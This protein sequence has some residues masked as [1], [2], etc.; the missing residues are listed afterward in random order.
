M[1]PIKHGMVADAPVSRWQLEA[2]GWRLVSPRGKIVALTAIEQCVLM[3]LMNTSEEPVLR[4][5]LIQALNHSSYDCDPH[6]LEMIIHRLRRKVLSQAKEM[7]PL[8]TVRGKG[9]L[10]PRNAWRRPTTIVG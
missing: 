3:T 4:E 8:L 9:Y 6:R 5:S 7:L 10:L 1:T 2:D